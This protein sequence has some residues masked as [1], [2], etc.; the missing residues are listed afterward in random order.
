MVPLQNA[1]CGYSWSRL[2]CCTAMACRCAFKLSRDDDCTL[3]KARLTACH[4]WLIYCNCFVRVTR[5][6]LCG[7]K[8][9]SADPIA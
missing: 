3:V 8:V 1:D 5:T 7:L 9:F 4:P 6:T 2:R